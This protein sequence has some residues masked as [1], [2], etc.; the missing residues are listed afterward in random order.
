[1]KQDKQITAGW[2]EEAISDRV[3]RE[4]LSKGERLSRD[5]NEKQTM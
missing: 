2:E 1:M 3:G 5:L 4:V